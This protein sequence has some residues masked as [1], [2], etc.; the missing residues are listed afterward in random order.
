MEREALPA[1]GRRTRTRARSSLHLL[2][3]ILFG[4][5]LPDLLAA[6]SGEESGQEVTAAQGLTDERLRER[7]SQLREERAAL[8]PEDA[9]L[10]GLQ[11]V[12]DLEL[13]FLDEQRSLLVDRAS[14]ERLQGETSPEDLQ[15]AADSKQ[16]ALAELDS[17][18]VDVALAPLRAIDNLEELRARVETDF[19]A[20]LRAASSEKEQ[21]ARLLEDARGLQRDLPQMI[22]EA[23]SRLETRRAEILQWEQR[24][25]PDLSPSEANLVRRRID[26]RR[27]G[28]SILEDRIAYLEERELLLEPLVRLF[29]ARHDAEVARFERWK[30][31][32]EAAQKELEKRIAAEVKSLAAELNAKQAELEA[33]RSP[34][35]RLFLTAKIEQLET[36]AELSKLRSR[37]QDANG[38]GAQVAL[39]LTEATRVLRARQS[40]VGSDRPKGDEWKQDEVLTEIMTLESAVDRA[41]YRR[42]ARVL[43]EALRAS[44]LELEAALAA[45]DTFEA[46]F[47]DKL[48]SAE[49]AFREEN[50]ALSATQVDLAWDVQ[51]RKWIA[52]KSELRDSL[53]ERRGITDE[54]YRTLSRLAEDHSSLDSKRRETLVLLQRRHL[55]LRGNSDIS[56]ASIRQGFADLGGLPESLSQLA[57]RAQ[58]Y[59]SQPAALRGA[60]TCSILLVLLGILL[61]LIN[62]WFSSHLLRAHADLVGER[63]DRIG[64]SLNYLARAAIR[65]TFLFL[66]FYLPG[67]T[68]PDLSVGVSQLFTGLGLVAGGFW[69]LRRVLR[70]F[71]G[72]PP[73]WRGLLPMNRGSAV[74]FFGVGTAIQYLSLIFLPVLMGLRQLEYGNPGMIE[75]LGMAYR[76]LIGLLLLM[77]LVRR[78]TFLGWLPEEGHPLGKLSRLIFVVLHPFVVLLVPG[79]LILDA[80]QYRV[81]AGL[82]TSVS[83]V[84]VVVALT[85]WLVYHG[86]L[87]GIGSLF[88]ARMPLPEEEEEAEPVLERRTVLFKLA[89]FALG[90][91]TLVVGAWAALALRGNSLKDLRGFL[92][93]RLP[94]QE[95]GDS[96]PV[97]LWNLLVASFLLLLTFRL[98]HHVKVALQ[99]LIL[100]KTRFDP[101]LQYTITTMT[102]YL[103]VALG[104]YL[105]LEQIF[106][107]ENLGYVVAALSIGI[108]FGLQEVI[109]NFISGLIL[110]FERPLRV[111]DIV[112]VG[113]TEGIVKRIQI[114]STTVLTRE[115]VW[116]LVPNKDF[117][118]EKVTN[119]VYTDAKVRLHISIGVAYGSDTAL[120]RRALLEVARDHGKVLKR[121][122]PEVWFVGFGDSSLD[123][124]LL[125]WVEDPVQRH[126]VESDLRFA[127]DAAFRRYEIKIPFPQRD[128]HLVSTELPDGTIERLMRPEPEALDVEEGSPQEA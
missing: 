117:I 106:D 47:D 69:M 8:D 89:R 55:F 15:A 96:T 72:H 125:A 122:T 113:G 48:S 62:R 115:N 31:L 91:T 17:L 127:I 40:A 102:G 12:I 74:R 85:G 42:E 63:T 104:L 27:Q 124:E 82:I 78:S 111:G 65:A 95:V 66:L 25:A 64:L 61:L 26:V 3:A 20:P 92:S 123:F 7:I 93:V 28:V 60:I 45:H 112:D 33:A 23:R 99:T 14:L 118:T 76:I 50:S 107:L 75:L 109:S 80:L 54:L 49:E 6:Q 37:L 84:L 119:F 43:R 4:L 44:R 94:M 2:L 51:R 1:A 41:R 86:L 120:V 116:I 32:N 128:L 9:N 68:L 16:E 71:I 90:L 67:R 52:L 108:G 79:L 56:L 87:F 70:V 53:E 101:G 110:L 58:R 30:R 114:R 83:V 24:L 29:D 19:T 22:A 121:P 18:Q 88:E 36:R 59:L 10:E 46:D 11:R 5:H 126:R 105:A 77:V 73:E 35:E 38:R 81:L 21:A 39:D 13:L 103:V 100:P 34:H 97:T 57:G 98:A